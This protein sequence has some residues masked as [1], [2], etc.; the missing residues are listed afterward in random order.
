MKKAPKHKIDTIVEVEYT[1]NIKGV[2]YTENDIIN[3]KNIEYFLKLIHSD[4]VVNWKVYQQGGFNVLGYFEGLHTPIIKDKSILI[5]F[6]GGR[7]SAFMCRLIQLH[8]GFAHYKKIFVFAN[9]GKE[10]EETLQFVDRCDKEFGL[11]LNWIEA[12]VHPKKGV[13]TTYKFTDFE[14]TSRNGE[15]FEDV[16]A[17]YGVPSKQFPHCTRELKIN[18]IRAFAR[19]LGINPEVAV[20]IRDDEQR[21]LNR[22]KSVWGD[23]I[24]YPLVDL[25][26]ANEEFIRK[27]WAKQPFD[28]ELKDYQGNL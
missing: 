17:K 22:D 18:P 27:W 3:P 8:E 11:N 16:I 26:K 12:K 5:S 23:K 1:T 20:G 28:L 2:T 19:N 24:R 21:R 6:S 15:P 13:G 4:D 9:T 7:T 10:R 25:L 14:H